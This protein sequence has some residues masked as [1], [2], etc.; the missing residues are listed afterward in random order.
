MRSFRHDN[1]GPFYAY[2]VETMSPFMLI[3]Q[4]PHDKQ[5]M[6]P[7]MLITSGNNVP[8]YAYQHLISRCMPIRVWKKL[9]IAFTQN[10]VFFRSGLSGLSFC[11][12]Q[13]TQC[14]LLGLPVL[15][16][17][18]TVVVRI[19]GGMHHG[20]TRPGGRWL[21][22]LPCCRASNTLMGPLHVAFCGSG[23]RVEVSCY[24]FGW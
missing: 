14:D 5:T 18:P 8:F 13:N 2:H 11:S 6:S 7:F 21:S 19:R 10:R 9:Y 12:R 16:V 22:Q 23:T 1:D 15:F 4:P 24:S 20:R 17:H 3:T